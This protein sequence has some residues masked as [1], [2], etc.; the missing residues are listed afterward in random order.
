LIVIILIAALVG[1]VVYL[2]IASNP[3]N[4]FPF[5]SAPSGTVLAEHY[6]SLLLIFVNDQQL[7]LPVNIGEGD[8]GACTQP[9]HV[10]Q[11]APSTN[12]I[13]IESPTL[14]NYALNDFLAVWKATPGI[15]GP[16]PVVITSQQLF[17]YSAGNGFEVRMSVNG[18][19][20]AAFGSFVLQ[21][22]MTIVIVYGKTSGTQWD[23][24]QAKS[25]Q[26]W[27]Y[28]GY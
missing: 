10:H 13:H 28:P 4:G 20:S 26:P 5:P 14:Q 16:K 15:E 9:L 11:T 24:Y 17:N 19:P 27:P 22:H 2:I 23:V 8:S 12:V 6:H 7:N 25:A 3:C 1:G 21:D 18:K